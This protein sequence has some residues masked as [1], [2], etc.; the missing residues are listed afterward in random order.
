ML[1][2]NAIDDRCGTC[3]GDGTKCKAI[4]GFFNETGIRNS[5][6]YSF[7][8]SKFSIQNFPTSVS[9]IICNYLQVKA[10]TIQVSMEIRTLETLL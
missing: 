10:L 7:L 4:E 2:S 1:D 8:S 6:L 9:S 3:K 5:K